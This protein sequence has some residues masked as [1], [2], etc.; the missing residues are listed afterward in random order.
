MGMAALSHD[1]AHNLET[2][3]C[4]TVVGPSLAI[5]CLADAEGMTSM[6]GN[7]TTTAA[8]GR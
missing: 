6:T 3:D 5:I 8:S 1:R 2:C 7:V 4:A